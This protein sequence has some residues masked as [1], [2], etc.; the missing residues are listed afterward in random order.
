M[1]MNS[2][3]FYNWGSNIKYVNAWGPYNEIGMLPYRY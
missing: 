2:A 3:K 1:M